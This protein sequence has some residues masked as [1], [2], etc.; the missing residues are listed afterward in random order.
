[1]L[2]TI[3]N[4]HIKPFKYEVWIIILLMLIGFVLV[5]LL[6]NKFKANHGPM[7]TMLDIIGLVHGA[8][9]QQGKY[10]LKHQML[11]EFPSNYR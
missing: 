5:L 6:L 11:Q 9:C 3:T 4:I 8:I 2:S 1:M 10:Y 7:V